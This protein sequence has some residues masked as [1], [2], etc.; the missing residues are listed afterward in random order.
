MSS[1]VLIRR[2][3]ANNIISFCRKTTLSKHVRRIHNA[4]PGEEFAGEDVDEELEDEESPSPVTNEAP[5]NVQYP[6]AQWTLP[7]V[8]PELS[9]LSQASPMPGQFEERPVKLEALIQATPFAGIPGRPTSDLSYLNY[10]HPERS[11]GHIQNLTSAPLRRPGLVMQ[12]RHSNHSSFD[13]PRSAPRVQTD[14]DM[15]PSFSAEGMINPSLQ[16]SPSSLSDGSTVPDSSIS[17]DYSRN[18]GFPTTQPQM[19]YPA[20]PTLDPYS[21]GCNV[22]AQAQPAQ[23][24]IYSEPPNM[25]QQYRHDQAQQEMQRQRE[26]RYQEAQRQE[27]HQVAS[28]RREDELRQLQLQQMQ[29]QQQQRHQQEQEQQAQFVH[30]PQDDT[31]VYRDPVPVPPSQPMYL[32]PTGYIDPLYDDKEYMADGHMMPSQR[33]GDWSTTY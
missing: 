2:A 32:S 5:Q 11:Q 14:A 17:Q 4:L 13:S 19:Q 30:V 7:V 18:F 22:S 1:E 16:A 9:Y 25:A 15:A 29:L 33:F 10:P 28:L 20:T 8:T 6:R 24:F 21:I 12:T 31:Y 27:I 26:A 3:K 23:P